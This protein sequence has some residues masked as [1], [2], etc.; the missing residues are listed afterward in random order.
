M[1]GGQVEQI[2]YCIQTDAVAKRKLHK[3]LTCQKKAQ[4]AIE[5]ILFAL[6]RYIVEE[7]P[8]LRGHYGLWREKSARIG[9]KL[10]N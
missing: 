10:N 4:L 2:V 3:H 5:K 1:S 8:I 9:A 7:L 6:R